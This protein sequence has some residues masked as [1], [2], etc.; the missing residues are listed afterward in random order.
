MSQKNIVVGGKW[1]IS[2][3]LGKGSFG[4]IYS[5]VNIKTNE[6]VAI[7]IESL[8]SPLPTLNYEAKILKQL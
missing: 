6:E 2:K 4:Q 8:R 7:K 1:S 3:T 5:G